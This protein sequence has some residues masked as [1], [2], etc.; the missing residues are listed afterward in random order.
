MFLFEG[1]KPFLQTP[2]NNPFNSFLVEKKSQT[3]SY[4]QFKTNFTN[5]FP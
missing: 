1:N 2:I 4:Q 3:F 5:D